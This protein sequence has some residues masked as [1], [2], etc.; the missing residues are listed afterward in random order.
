MKIIAHTIKGIKQGDLFFTIPSVLAITAFGIVAATNGQLS[1][2]G[3]GWILWSFVLFA[4]A[5]V[6]FAQ[7]IVPFQKQ[8]TK[9]VNENN[10]TN[11]FDWVLL[12]K[13][14]FQWKI[15]MLIVLITPLI[16]FVLMTFKWPY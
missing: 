10:S 12:K 16:A 14:F 3:T 4:I 1:L 11:D 2:V 6:V 5:V 13:V 15:W 9:M 7:R 8:I